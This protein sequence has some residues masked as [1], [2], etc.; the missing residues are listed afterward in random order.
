MVY[1]KRGIQLAYGV[2]PE[3]ITNGILGGLTIKRG[4]TSDSDELILF[5]NGNNETVSSVDALGVIRGKSFILSGGTA[6]QLLLANGGLVSFNTLPIISKMCVTG[7]TE[8][9]G[10]PLFISQTFIKTT[11][12]KAVYISTGINSVSDWFKI[13]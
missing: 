10:T 4:S 7:N 6:N 9:F 1:K 11:D 13:G 8:P 2:Q 3:I 12:V 5:K